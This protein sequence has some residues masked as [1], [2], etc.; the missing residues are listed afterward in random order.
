MMKDICE[1]VENN[2]NTLIRLN[3]GTFGLGST[4]L[5]QARLSLLITAL[6]EGATMLKS[7]KVKARDKWEGRYRGLPTFGEDGKS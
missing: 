3:L 5:N 4:E 1:L 7:K 6:H 2:G